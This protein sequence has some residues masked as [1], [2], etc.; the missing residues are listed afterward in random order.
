MRKAYPT[1]RVSI[2]WGEIRVY[3]YEIFLLLFLSFFSFFFF[4]FTL[5]F[6][7]FLFYIRLSRE[8]MVSF[9]CRSIWRT[10][11]ANNIP[12]I[13]NTFVEQLCCVTIGNNVSRHVH[14]TLEQIYIYRIRSPITFVAIVAIAARRLRTPSPTV[15]PSHTAHTVRRPR[16]YHN[17]RRHRSPARPAHHLVDRIRGIQNQDQNHVQAGLPRQPPAGSYR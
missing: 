7:F 12:P 15:I 3:I 6:S 10:Y 8:L 4:F 2:E 5:S 16:R 9:N 14:I 1:E 13:Y 17:T 11:S